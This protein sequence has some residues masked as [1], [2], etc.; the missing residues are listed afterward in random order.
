RAGLHGPGRPLLTPSRSFTA[1]V[2]TRPTLT[3]LDHSQAR[4]PVLPSIKLSKNNT[5]S[6]W[7][8]GARLEL[9]RPRKVPGA[10]SLIPESHRGRRESMSCCRVAV[11]L[12]SLCCHFLL[13]GKQ[14]ELLVVSI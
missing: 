9:T 3:H 6:R 8:L 7:P 2:G 12:L 13:N 14:D 10:P 1:R 5:A 11:E 4:A